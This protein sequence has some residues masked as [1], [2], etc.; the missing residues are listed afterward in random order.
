MS[1]NET[2]IDDWTKVPL[3]SRDM[4]RAT[5]WVQYH[6]TSGAVGETDV[7]VCHTSVQF[8]KATDASY[9]GLTFNP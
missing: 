8:R 9:F 4:L 1:Y 6:V 5:N 3:D 7:V 2:I